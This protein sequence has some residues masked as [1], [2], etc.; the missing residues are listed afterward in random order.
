MDEGNSYIE[1]DP[2]GVKRVA[3]TRI[4]I[5]SVV[6]AFRQGQSAE[7]IQRNFPA[8]SLEQV[9]GTIAYYL[10]H[11][12]EV[13]NYLTRQRAGWEE[14]RARTEQNPSAALERLRQ[15]RADKAGH[16]Q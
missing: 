16:P 11:R 9:Y 15:A 7:E 5:D 4:S 8:L 14:L 6:I 13:E 3:G 2:H 12:Q 1:T 10:G